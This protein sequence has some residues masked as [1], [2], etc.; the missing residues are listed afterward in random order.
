MRSSFSFKN[1]RNAKGTLVIY[2]PR[3]Y[4]FDQVDME[5]GA[6]T[7]EIDGLNAKSLKIESGASGCTIKNA[8]IEELDVET[9]AG[10]LDFYGTVEKEVDI[11]CGAGSVTLNL[12]GKV[13]DYNYELDSS[14]G[15]VEI[16]EDID[17]G[18]LSTE[19]SIDNGSKRTIEISNGAG[20]VEI[21]FH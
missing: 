8:D 7:A 18:G 17:L 16:G 1:V 20:S 15:S 6:V 21:R 2:L 5:Y 4:K 13:E 10:S 11:D 14:A 3:D 12:E 9:G 19:K